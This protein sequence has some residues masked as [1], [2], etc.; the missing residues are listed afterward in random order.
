MSSKKD[1]SGWEYPPNEIHEVSLMLGK[2]D[3]RLDNIETNMKQFYIKIDNMNIALTNA[4]IK[5][6]GV[7]VGLSI[8][9]TIIINI[10]LNM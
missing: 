1:K 3:A 2:I 6:G 8:L 7:T 9:A 5:V 4:R 10:V